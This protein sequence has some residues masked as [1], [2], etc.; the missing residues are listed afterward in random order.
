MNYLNENRF[1]AATLSSTLPP[2]VE[3][4]FQRGELFRFPSDGQPSV[5]LQLEQEVAEWLGVP[6]AVATSSGTAGLKTALIACG[7]KPGDRVLVPAFTFIA[8]AA[9]VVSLGAVPEPFDCDGGL[10]IDVADLEAR[11][12]AGVKAALAV[13][14]Q[15]HAVDLREVRELLTSRKVP[16]V[17]DACQ[18]FGAACMS[19]PAGTV[20]DLGVFSFQQSKQLS[21][22][23]GG[24]IVAGDP[25]L[26]QRCARL[27]DLGAVRDDRGLPDWDSPHA[28][29]GENHRMTE[30]QAAVLI[31]QMA[32]LKQMLARQTAC[33]AA[34]LDVLG[35]G[36]SASVLFSADPEGDAASHLLLKMES[37]ESALSLIEHTAKREVLVRRVWDRPYYGHA[38]FDR[39]GLAPARLGLMPA[40]RAEELAP[41]L[42]SVP[43]P[44]NLSSAD[45]ETVGTVILEALRR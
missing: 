44:G 14:V 12:H 39:L 27:T 41:R 13:H 21:S 15:G 25:D 38:V 2:S 26:L 43:T 5:C 11:L 22:G 1:G 28:V 33:R 40:R 19:R 30:V 45:A 10:G 29:I 18:G 32:D 6:G 9:A 42:V 4:V 8:T 17:E 24:M 20:G 31:Q 36:A 37:A 3:A 34:I 7:V 16:L 23:E 35:E